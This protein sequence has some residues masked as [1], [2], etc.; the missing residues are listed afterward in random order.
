MALTSMDSTMNVVVPYMIHNEHMRPIE[1]AP[2]IPEDMLELIAARYMGEPTK[3]HVPRRPIRTGD[4][5]TLITRTDV[6]MAQ[7]IQL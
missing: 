2:D 1:I 3:V 5:L 4:E 7:E 6:I